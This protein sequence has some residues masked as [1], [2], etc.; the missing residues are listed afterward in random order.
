MF[1]IRKIT[2]RYD[3]EQDRIGLTAQ[4]DEGRVLLLWLTQRLTNRLVGKLASWLD[5]DVKTM[6]SGR[7]MFS[8]HAWEQSSAEV[9]LKPDRPV[10]AAAVQGEALLTA[11]DLARDPSGY[12]LTFKWGSAGAARLRLNPT[13]LRQSL[14]ILHRLFDTAGWPK[15]A[16]PEWFA[17]GE[18]SG[19]SSTT[20]HVLH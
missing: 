9:Q 13:E 3:P 17:A 5:E 8:P 14:I 2:Q 4:N 19:A 10:D 18:G 20:H 1:A 7:P 11:V 12:T 6:P 15:H 16:W